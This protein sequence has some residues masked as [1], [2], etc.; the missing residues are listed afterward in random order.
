[1]VAI[2]H[3][4]TYPGSGG[5]KSD[6]TLLIFKEELFTILKKCKII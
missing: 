6:P 1:M 5:I 3:V 2:G 4:I